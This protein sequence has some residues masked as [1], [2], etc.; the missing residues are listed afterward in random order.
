MH[1]DLYSWT[2]TKTTVSL[3]EVKVDLADKEAD[4]IEMPLS[5]NKCLEGKLFEAELI[6][7]QLEAWT[8]QQGS[9]QQLG[10]K[11]VL[12]GI[13]QDKHHFKGLTD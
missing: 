2:P 11:S 7:A 8:A 5:C 1:Y 10:L 9:F 4:T 3:I 6:V 13:N 12:S